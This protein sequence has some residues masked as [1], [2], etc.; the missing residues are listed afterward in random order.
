MIPE[1]RVQKI[2]EVV[3]KIDLYWRSN[4]AF[5]AVPQELRELLGTLRMAVHGVEGKK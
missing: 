3:E 1:E 2:L 4:W 5:I